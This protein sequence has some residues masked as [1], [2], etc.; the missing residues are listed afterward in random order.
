MG[1]TPPAEAPRNFVN[2]FLSACVTRAEPKRE[3]APDA[4]TEAGGR[5]RAAVFREARGACPC[6]QPA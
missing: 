1:T 3:L 4:R 6:A 2:E 5:G